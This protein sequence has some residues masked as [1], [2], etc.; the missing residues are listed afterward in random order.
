[1]ADGPT[2]G[3]TVIPQRVRARRHA[4]ARV[5]DAR[6]AGLGDEHRVLRRRGLQRRQPVVD[7]RRVG[8][9]PDLDD[10]QAGNRL[11]VRNGLEKGARAA[12]VLGQEIVGLA[13]RGERAG[14]QDL[15][16]RAGF[17][18][19]GHRDQVQATGRRRRAAHG[20]GGAASGSTMPKAASMV[21]RRISGRPISAVGSVL[22]T[23][24]TRQIP[25]DSIFAAP[26]QS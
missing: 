2:H 21:V 14:G 19:D 26:A 20:A 25:S 13:R 9:V 18:A 5:G 1:M 6:A 7:A 11:R 4:G 12:R 22:S 16:R 3:T 8:L 15:Q 23:D 17:V 10:R 24:S